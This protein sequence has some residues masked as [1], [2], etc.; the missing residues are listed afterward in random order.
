MSLIEVSLI[1][2]TACIGRRHTG[3]VESS[4]PYSGL[5]ALSLQSSA[6][7]QPRR[8]ECTD[9]SKTVDVQRRH[10]RWGFSVAV[11]SGVDP[12]HGALAP[13]PT[14]GATSTTVAPRRVATR[15]SHARPKPSHRLRTNAT[16]RRVETL[17][18]GRRGGGNT[19]TSTL[20]RVETFSFLTHGPEPCP[21]SVL[22]VVAHAGHGGRGFCC[23]TAWL[24][25]PS[26]PPSVPARQL[27]RA[28]QRPRLA[29]PLC[30][31]RRSCP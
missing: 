27:Q 20:P 6:R 22:Y 17:K 8:A 7:P 29:A 4:T 11:S 10:G 30:A 5:R 9:A 15:S 19:Q 26:A 31:C 24:A 1:N 14:P 3:G 12:R 21:V 2:H 18:P 23:I 25:T 16:I 28:P 13:H